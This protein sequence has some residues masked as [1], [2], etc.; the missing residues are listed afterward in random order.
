R[1]GFNQSELLA[2]EISRRTGVPLVH[3][4]KRVRHTS[5]QAGLTNTKRRDNVL[6]AFQ[7]KRRIW[8]RALPKHPGAFLKGL[9]VLLIDDVMTTGA[10]AGACADVIRKAGAAHVTVLTLARVDRR[11]VAAQRKVQ[12]ERFP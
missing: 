3:V 2:R 10:T 5:A 12:S 8:D 6:R 7:V 11:F 9:R 4:I 1:R